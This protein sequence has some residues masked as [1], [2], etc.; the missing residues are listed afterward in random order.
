MPGEAGAAVKTGNHA[1]QNALPAESLHNGKCF[2]QQMPV[3]NTKILHA[4][5]SFAFR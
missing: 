2:L 5:C 1:R 3:C 4:A